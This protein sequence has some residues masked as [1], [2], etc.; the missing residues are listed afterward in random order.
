MDYKTYFKGKKITIMGLG[1]IGKG[2]LDPIFL[3]KCGADIIAT[4]I[5]SAKELKPTVDKLKKFK[6]I[7]FVLGGHRL[8]DFEN[9][10]L[11]LKSQGIPLH[12]PFIEHARENS[13]PVEMDE[14][15]F[16][17]LAQGVSVV[18]VTGTRG[19]TTTTMLIYN[20]L[21]KAYVKKQTKV[22]LAGNLPGT[23]TL[24]L[25]AKVKAGDIVVLE[26]SSWQLQGFGDSKISP[27]ISV[28]INFMN[29]HLNYYNNDLEKYFDDKTNIFKFQK[30]GDFL[31][32]GESLENNLKFK[33]SQSVWQQSGLRSNLEIVNSQTIPKDW[34]IRIPGE[35][36]R[37]NAGFA[38]KVAKVM[39]VKDEVI[40]NVLEKFEGVEGRLQFIKKYKGVSIWNDNNSTTPEATIAALRALGE[41]KNII[42]IMGGDEKNLDMSKLVEEIPKKAKAVVL[43]KETGTDRVKKDIFGL[44]DVLVFEES[45]LKNCFKRA[46]GL[47][48]RGDHILFSPAFSSFGKWFKNEY[49][50]N[51]QFLKLVKG[52]K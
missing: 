14:S 27:H 52:L 33:N 37:E 7:K 3:A 10:D 1:L 18:G 26:L 22:F 32:V 51:D 38:V 9:R 47:A 16:M 30:E 39:G 19:K 36:N 23:A 46:V 28:F 2:F 8:E 11:I 45:G 44:E 31:I 12:S 43:F 6:N 34:K 24:P 25:L 35:H 5:K 4:D 20:I 50:R 48:E 29:D 15:L 21:K 41:N 13:I 40:K 17:K 42:L 49:D